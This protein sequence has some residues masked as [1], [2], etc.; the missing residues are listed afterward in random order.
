MKLSEFDYELPDH[1][2]AQRPAEP[3]DSARLLVH[4]VGRDETEHAFIR[5]LPEIL[6]SGDLLVV[7]DTRVLPAR[8]LG[9]RVSG[10]AVEVLV[11]GRAEEGG[12]WRALVRPAKRLSP[13]ES[14]HLEGG[15][16][17]ARACERLPGDDGR[18]GAEWTIELSEPRPGER[19]VEELLELFGRMPLPP[20]IH[21]EVDE[22]PRREADRTW[23]QTVFARVPG[24]VAAPTAGLHLTPELL[25]QLD[26]RGI[27]RTQITL[28][29][30]IGT[31]RP[32]VAERI[33]D[34]AMHSEEFVVSEEAA[35][36]VA[37]A[38]NSGGRVIAVGTT[39]ARALETCRT[40]SGGIRAGSGRTDIFIKPGYAFAALDGLITNFHLPRSTLLMLVSAFAGR[41]RV[42]R[43][44][45]E[46]IDEGY[47]FYSYGDAMLLLP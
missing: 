4:Q 25:G 44:Y 27:A 10:G 38:R 16:L 3:R 28:H 20:Y 31:F 43:L 41:E 19:S 15:S 7:N 40:P 9:R 26:Q 17:L 32:V 37:R 30:G 36:A 46:A 5:D 23:Y 18:P 12:R 11:L 2:I 33:E 1:R 35:D 21:R 6:R 22:D 8:L 14:I 24:A 29:V 39:S 34:H 13:G 47:R 42:L 45:R